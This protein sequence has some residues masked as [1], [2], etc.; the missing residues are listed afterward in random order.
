MAEG[1]D[2][3][4]QYQL[5]TPYDQ[6]GQESVTAALSVKQKQR[7][8]QERDDFRWLMNTRQ[9]RRTVWRQLERAGIY[10][11]SFNTNAMSMAFAEGR[12]NE[13]LWITHMIHR[14]C[15]DKNQKMIEE[16]TPN[17]R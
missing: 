7:I 10:Q 2:N 1:G 12:K 5:P 3:L 13:G 9:G 8:K 15:P 4:E 17:E 6:K 16:N 14:Y 11:P